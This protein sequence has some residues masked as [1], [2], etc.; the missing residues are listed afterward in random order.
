MKN[1]DLGFIVRREMK[2][3]IVI[4]KIGTKHMYRKTENFSDVILGGFDT[5]REAHLFADNHPRRSELQGSCNVLF[6]K[7]EVKEVQW[8]TTS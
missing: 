3:Y 5:E 1:K 8:F 6:M 2:R 7:A 4:Q